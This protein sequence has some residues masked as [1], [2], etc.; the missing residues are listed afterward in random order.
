MGR[1]RKTSEYRAVGFRMPA[2]RYVLLDAVAREKGVDLSAVLNELVA[3]AA[4]RL[5]KWLI[6]RARAGDPLWGEMLQLAFQV[7]A[8][9]M[10]P[11]ATREAKRPLVERMVA[12]GKD[13]LAMLDKTKKEKQA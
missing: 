6:E 3:E 1:K 9:E 12:V 8:L 13:V 4:P 7:E 2:H 11:A 5:Q 10:D